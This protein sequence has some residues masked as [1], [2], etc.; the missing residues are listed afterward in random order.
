MQAGDA[1]RPAE[2][3]AWATMEVERRN[4]LVAGKTRALVKLS[5]DGGALATR[6]SFAA[7][8]HELLRRASAIFFSLHS[9]TLRPAGHKPTAA[10]MDFA[11]LMSAQIEK[12]KSSTPDD[13]SKKYLKRSEVEAQRQAAYLAEQKQAEQQ[14]L[15]KLEKKRK[16][17]EEEQER[18]YERQEKKRRLAEQSRKLREEEEEA[19]ERERRK[20][21]GLP[22]LPP[23]SK[24]SEEEE[25]PLPDGEQDIPDEE[26]V[27]KL[28][29]LEEPARLFGETHR[30]RLKRYKRLTGQSATAKLHDGPI[31]TT[32]EPVPGGQ[33]LVAGTLPKDVEGKRFLGRQLGSYFNMV[34]REWEIA[35]AQR[36]DEVKTS[37]QGKQAYNAM[38]QAKENLRPLFRKLEKDEVEDSVLEAVVEIVKAAQD[39]RYVDANDGYLRL[40]I[41]K[42]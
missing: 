35:L 37:F 2:L 39:R 7:R 6:R 8:L 41:G 4:G 15:E 20:R 28:R 33:M 42:A 13:S 22:D 25:T 19:T 9:P 11:K 16:L 36:P 31:P 18:E 3:G 30:Q 27:E 14:R 26:L 40:S 17:E 5:S 29:G 24:E 1:T 32:L 23:K 38:V 10:K 34:L 21:L 12:G